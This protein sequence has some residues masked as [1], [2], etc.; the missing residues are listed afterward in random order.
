LTGLVQIDIQRESLRK[1]NKISVTGGVAQLLNEEKR[2][3]GK[4]VKQ[5]AREDEANRREERK[6][7]H[8]GFWNWM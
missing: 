5:K 3:R 4:E 6:I 7:P 8:D 1:V 2:K